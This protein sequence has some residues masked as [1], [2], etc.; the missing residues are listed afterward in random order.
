M[1]VSG[2]AR[3]ALDYLFHGE[4]GGSGDGLDVHSVVSDWNAVLA[5]LDQSGPSA[6][7]AVAR[8]D[9]RTGDLPVRR[10]KRII[11][12]R[13]CQVRRNDVLDVRDCGRPDRASD[14]VDLTEE[15][16]AALGAKH[17]GDG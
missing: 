11:E 1:L 7:R 4:T 15:A 17:D 3:V 8:S 13:Q 12:H 10:V 14:G 9:E 6:R 5:G 16:G 2:P